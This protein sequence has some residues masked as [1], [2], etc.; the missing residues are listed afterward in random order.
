MSLGR[1]HQLFPGSVPLL[2]TVGRPPRHRRF[3]CG[4]QKPTGKCLSCLVSPTGW[5]R[6]LIS[7]PPLGWPG[8]ASALSRSLVCALVGDPHPMSM[9][10]LLGLSVPPHTKEPGFSL[11]LLCPGPCPLPAHTLAIASMSGCR[12]QGKPQLAQADPLSREHSTQAVSGSICA[13]MA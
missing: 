13:K 8:L 7:S 11:F 10:R 6:E 5:P 3:P 1:P 2:L 4:P 12:I 9:S